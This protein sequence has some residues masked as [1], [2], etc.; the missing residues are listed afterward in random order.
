ME[1]SQRTSTRTLVAA[2]VVAVMA[3][4]ALAAV[5]SPAPHRAVPATPRNILRPGLPL[6]YKFGDQSRIIHGTVA[7]HG[8]FPYQAALYMDSS[9]F[10]G[11]S[12]ISN[13]WVLTAGH[14]GY[15]HTRF[16]IYLGA[17]EVQKP[18]ENGREVITSTAGMVHENYNPNLLDNDVCLVRLPRE[19]K[20]TPLIQTINLPPRSY[21]SQSF[22][23]QAVTVSGWGKPTD[24][25]YTISP[26]LQYADL[27]VISNAQ[28]AQEYGNIISSK[29]I[30]CAAP[31]GLSTCNGDS[32]GPL[33]KRESDGTVTHIGVVSFVSSRGCGS[34]APS[35][36]D[37]T[38]SFLDWISAKTGIAIR[39]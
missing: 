38:A 9:S 12:L 18:S 37:R 16:T 20:L 30:C 21:A 33:V 8:Q 23:G 34:G 39:D 13:Q 15:R 3:V 22:E 36:Y 31:G 2:L 7:K 25:S 6:V 5:E 1:M 35:G 28:C 19:I 27:K 32:G 4:Q 11:G 26:V 29:I 14:C 10:C 17:Q 24:S